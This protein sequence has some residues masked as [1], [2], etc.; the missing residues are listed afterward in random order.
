MLLSQIL[1]LNILLANVLEIIISLVFCSSLS[2]SI[3]A[4]AKH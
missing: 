4:T 3:A 1:L 2:I